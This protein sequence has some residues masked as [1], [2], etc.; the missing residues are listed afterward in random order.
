M[1]LSSIVAFVLLISFYFVMPALILLCTNKVQ[2]IKRYF[3]AFIL[4]FF[5]ILFIGVFCDVIIKSSSIQISFDFSGE[6]FNK[7]IK[8]DFKAVKADKIINLFMLVPVGEYVFVK[9]SDKVLKVYCCRLLWVF[10]W[11]L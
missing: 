10:A 1:K 3:G 8:L 6:W 11:V 9:N 2:K 4:L 5:C 7:I